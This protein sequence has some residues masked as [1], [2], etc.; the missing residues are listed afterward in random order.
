MKSY[1]YL[2]SFSYSGSTLLSFLLNSHPKITSVGELSGPISGIN[3]N[4]FPCSCGSLLI[5]CKFWLDIQSEM[6]KLNLPLELS[7][8]NTQYYSHIK[9]SFM[10]KSQLYTSKLSIFNY[11]KDILF[12]FDQSRA[13]HIAQVNKRCIKLAEIITLKSKT[14]FFFDASKDSV[15]LKYLSRCKDIDLKVIFL[16]RDARSLVC[17]YLER[18]PQLP[19][20]EIAYIWLRDTLRREANIKNYIKP[21]QLINIRY[22]DLCKNTEATL[23]K[24]YDFIGVEFNPL[25]FPLKPENHHIIG[26]RM[27]LGKIES[28]S[29]NEKWKNELSDDQIS[30]IL[31]IVGAKNE[32]YG[33]G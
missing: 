28:I 9:K 23:T 19:I 2:T 25:V 24:I 21:K 1:I 13:K 11:I 20:G 32:H 6:K 3:M 15:M 30:T 27:R 7:N 5:N 16:K 31:D 26:N 12:D 22:E 18:Y 29:L 10:D 8:F 17:S 14:D 33:Y 4:T